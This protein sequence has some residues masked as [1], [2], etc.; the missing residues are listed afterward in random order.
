[1]TRPPTLTAT[2]AAILSFLP[3]DPAAALTPYEVAK[4]ISGQYEPTHP[5]PAAVARSLRALMRRG[6]VRQRQEGLQSRGMYPR[7]VYWATKGIA[8]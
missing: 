2:Q 4:H 7:Y 6:L 5:N 8:A 1:M 3:V